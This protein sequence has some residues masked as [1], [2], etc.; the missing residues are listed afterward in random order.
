[1]QR[2][3]KLNLPEHPAYT[4]I[5]R[6]A[7]AVWNKCLD[8]MNLYQYQ[9]GYPHAHRDFYFG[10]DCHTWMNTRLK[11]KHP[12]HSQSVQYVSYRYFA[13]WRSYST[14]KRN[15]NTDAR[16]PR[17]RRKHFTN[18]WLKSAIRFEQNLL[19]NYLFLSM[20]KGRRALDIKLPPAF[21]MTDVE[22]VVLVELVYHNNRHVLHIVYRDDAEPPDATGDE[23]LGIDL[24]EIHPMVTHDGKETLIFNGRYIRSLYR[25][26]NKVLAQFQK[27]LANRKKFSRRYR[28]LV[29]R[30][31]KYLHRLDRQIM[32]AFHKHTSKLRDVCVRRG[33]GTVVIG[34]LK[35]IRKRMDYGRRA[36]QKLHQ[37]AFGKLAS[38]I[39]YKC[40]AV[41]IKVVSCDEAYTSQTCPA[42]GE[43]RKP[44]NRNYRC[45][46]CG[47]TYH[48]DGV[49]AIN[50]RKKYLG[51]LTVPVAAA[52]IPPRGFRLETRGCPLASRQSRMSPTRSK[53]IPSL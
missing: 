13:A 45:K 26:R 46:A 9:R 50:I 11:G 36:N 14:H 2:T 39:T 37:W 38:M 24:G 25:L 43:R 1:M 41:G 12:L 30:K 5:A 27:L 49:G 10:K 52:M 51:H 15:G 8:L 18:S 17:K 29:Q 40:E 7:A 19:G 53:R 47:F 20:G 23:V 35:G 48:R 42:C 32:D 22:Q 31:W 34:D 3:K 6:E 44:T 4:E 28:R 16:P 21:D 33:I